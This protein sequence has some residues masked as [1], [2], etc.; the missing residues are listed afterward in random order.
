MKFKATPE[1]LS[2]LAANAVNASVPVGLG[3]LHATQHVFTPEEMRPHVE[4]NG[5]SLNLDYIQGR[6][7]KLYCTK[8]D[9]DLYETRDD[10]DVEYQSWAQRYPTVKALLES[11]PGIREYP[12][13][14][15]QMDIG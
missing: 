6:M 8:V 5:A 3:L 15:R 14:F 4:R 2:Q 11:V 1:Q 13:Q 12:G 10:I 7:V 9:K